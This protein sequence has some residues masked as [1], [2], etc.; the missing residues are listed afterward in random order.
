MVRANPL[1]LDDFVGPAAALGKMRELVKVLN[2][3]DERGSRRVVVTGLPGC[4]KTSM[5]VAAAV[6]AGVKCVHVYTA[7]DTFEGTVQRWFQEAQAKADGRTVLLMIDM[8]C[9]SVVT[10]D[11]VADCCA[12]LHTDNLV[13]VLIAETLPLVGARLRAT[14]S[15]VE[16]AQLDADEI[17][18]WA[19]RA[20]AI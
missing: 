7:A 11:M 5:V 15:H 19:R 4:G 1:R 8:T 3:E 20:T 17:H 10:Y 18:E 6:E 9:S 12:S 16:V 14:F 13:I 2:G